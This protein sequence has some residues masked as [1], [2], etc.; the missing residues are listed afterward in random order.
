MKITIST[1]TTKDFSTEKK[2]TKVSR[3][4]DKFPNCK[5]FNEIYQF[6]ATNIE[7]H[8]DILNFLSAEY[9]FVVDGHSE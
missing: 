6:V 1:Y 8:I 5:F 7:L 4:G 9:L 3:V 2:W